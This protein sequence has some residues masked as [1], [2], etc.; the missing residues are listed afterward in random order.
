MNT[1]RNSLGGAGDRTSALAFGGSGPPQTTNTEE[2]NGASWV[3]VNNLNT[4]RESLA[5]LG[6]STAALAFGGEVPPPSTATEEWNVPSNTV[7]T[8]TD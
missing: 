8:L 4:S 2:Y 6:T 1:A 5:G 7:K 3:E